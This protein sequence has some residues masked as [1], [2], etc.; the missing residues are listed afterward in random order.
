MP[1]MGRFF[2]TA[3]DFTILETLLNR[4]ANRD[5]FF[6]RLLREKLSTVMVAFHEDLD[7]QVATINSRIDFTADGQRSNN[8]VLTYGGED[9]YPDRCLP[10]TSLR[11]LALLGLMQ[12]ETIVVECSGDRVETIT[13]DAVLY[14]PEAEDRKNRLRRETLPKVESA[15]SVEA[16]VISFALHRRNI[17]ERPI[18]GPVNPDDDDPGPR[19]A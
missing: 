3:K 1:K 13:L 4:S 6:L 2:L 16:P 9:A 17:L 5:D 10:I 12:G 8:Q 19:A 18:E 14:Q 7:P 15:T 11:G